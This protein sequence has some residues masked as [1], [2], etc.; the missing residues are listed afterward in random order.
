VGKK[1]EEKGIPPPPLPRKKPK[2]R[3]LETVPAP[4]KETNL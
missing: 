1:K 3:L 4:M 2:I